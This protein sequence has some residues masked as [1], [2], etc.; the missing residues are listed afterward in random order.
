M[1]EMRLLELPCCPERRA[2]PTLTRIVGRYGRQS[3]TPSALAAAFLPVVHA[4]LKPVPAGPPPG[5][6]SG[7]LP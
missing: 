2:S 5:Y 7:P 6:I 3:R 1:E 4:G